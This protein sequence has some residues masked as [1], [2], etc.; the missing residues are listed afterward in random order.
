M[1][2]KI[3]ERKG[4]EEKR[5]EEEENNHAQTIFRERRERK[6]IVDT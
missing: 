1:G 3:K 5:F 6:K 2:R 4:Q